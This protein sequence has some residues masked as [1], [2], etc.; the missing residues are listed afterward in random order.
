MCDEIG[1]R[2]NVAIAECVKSLRR[3]IREQ[4]VHVIGHLVTEISN[5]RINEPQP[6]LWNSQ[7]T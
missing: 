6:L 2:N 3:D 1:M 7:E 4:V 5:A